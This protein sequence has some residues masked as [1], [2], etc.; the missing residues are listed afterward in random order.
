[1]DPT[2]V[3]QGTWKRVTQD[4]FGEKFKVLQGFQTTQTSKCNL[5][6]RKWVEEGDMSS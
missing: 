4:K 3:Q 1:L 6:I 5:C 2:W